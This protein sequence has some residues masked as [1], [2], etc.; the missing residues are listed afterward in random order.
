MLPFYCIVTKKTTFFGF[1]LNKRAGRTVYLPQDL[2][3]FLHIIIL[4]VSFLKKSS[5][6]WLS[7]TQG[8]EFAHSLIRSFHSNQMSD[9][10]W[11]AQVT[12]DKWATVSESLR[13]LMTNQG[14]WANRS[15]RSPKM[16]LWANRTFAHF[17]AKIERFAQNTDER[18]PSPV[19]TV[20]IIFRAMFRS[21]NF[22]Y[23]IVLQ[24]P[25]R[26]DF[27]KGIVFR[28]KYGVFI[29]KGLIL[30][31]KKWTSNGFT[32]LSNPSSKCYWFKNCRRFDVKPVYWLAAFCSTT[33][34]KFYDLKT[35]H[36]VL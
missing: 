31:L 30:S 27:K 15:G 7:V 33:Q 32:F 18:I 28:E 8:W 17:F 14:P 5:C 35:R 10:E 36:T 16:S 9:C 29:S 19:V 13:L 2:K 20:S 24:L 23:I 21:I 25:S 22:I 11:I 34:K 6:Y 26:T 3:V 12:Q 1:H 4:R